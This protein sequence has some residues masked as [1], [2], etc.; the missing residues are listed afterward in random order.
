MQVEKTSI[1]GAIIL[2]PTIYNDG[3]GYFYESYNKLKFVELGISEEFVQDNQSMSHKG[4]L[5]GL[6]F[7][8]QPYAQG[9][10]VRVISGAVIDVILD[11]RTQSPTYG[12]HIA[13]EL[14]AENK[15]M[16]WVPAGFA[17]GFSTLEDN[18][19]FQYKCTQFYNKE[20][21]GGVL[22]NS[23]SLQIDWRV[24]DPILSDKDLL[25]SDFSDFISPF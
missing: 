11:I 8:K 12:K 1:E 13:V 7:Q 24:K 21:E 18:T 5:R 25:L 17:H 16:L 19:I 23:P 3:R 2:K 9:K 6:H 20:S 4:A 22:W 15:H 10:L 14:T